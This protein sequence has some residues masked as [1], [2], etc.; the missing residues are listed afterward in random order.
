MYPADANRDTLRC[1]VT[2]HADSLTIHTW[3]I[4]AGLS[5]LAER[6]TIA[7]RVR[8][9]G[10]PP[11]RYTLMLDIDE[12]ESGRRV[13]VSVG[14]GDGGRAAMTPRES[15]A[16]VVFRRSSMRGDGSLPLGPL[17][18]VES[19]SEPLAMY[20]AVQAASAVR[21]RSITGLKESLSA[22][23]RG[24]R[25]PRL[26]EYEQVVRQPGNA[27]VVFQ[28]RAWD[29]SLG[30]DPADRE[31]VNEQRAQLI[32]AL[33]EE[34]GD[35]FMGGFIPSE[36]VLAHYGDLISSNLSSRSDYIRLLKSSNIGISTAGL[37]GSIPF[38]IGE[39]LVCG[40]AILS[41]PFR[42][43][44]EPQPGPAVSTFETSDECLSQVDRLLSDREVLAKRQQ[45]SYRYWHREARPDR[46]VERL[47]RTSLRTTQDA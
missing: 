2:L 32:R 28:T 30:S 10:Y 7:L 37:H 6:R 38:K 11:E 35:R 46:I 47:I 33:R 23:S 8:D 17:F 42:Y 20:L 31:A 4:L 34:V 22:V 25:F 16:D 45:A 1:R 24:S 36:F 21:N 40:L 19:G 39:Y 13:R 14:V 44:L 41:E 12:W 9:L 43:R 15:V 26:S 3:S 29:P 18:G 5:M 27:A